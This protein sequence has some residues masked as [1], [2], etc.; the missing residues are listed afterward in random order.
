MAPLQT[1]R[2]PLLSLRTTLIL[3]LGCVIPG[4]LRLAGVH[5]L[6]RGLGFKPCRNTRTLNEGDGL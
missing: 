3:L 4:G 6:G 5:P 2:P 1:R